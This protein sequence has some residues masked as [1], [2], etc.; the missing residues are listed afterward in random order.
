MS[1]HAVD[2]RDDG[3]D[4]GRAVLGH[5]LPDWLESTLR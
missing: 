1:E 5:E 4:V 2:V 3:F